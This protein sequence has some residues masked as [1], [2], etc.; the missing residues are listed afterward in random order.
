M[1]ENKITYS[2]TEAAQVL[3]LSRPTVYRLID[4]PDFPSVRVGSRVLIPCGL[5]QEWLEEQAT[6]KEAVL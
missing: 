4:R 3:G 6:R 2:V 1:S 5:L